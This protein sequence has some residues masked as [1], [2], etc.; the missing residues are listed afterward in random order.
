MFALLGALGLIVV[1]IGTLAAFGLPILGSL[2]L[3]V[4]GALG[5]EAGIARTLVQTTPLLFTSLGM[6]V[7]WRAGMG[8]HQVD[9]HKNRGP[10]SIEGRAHTLHSQS[11]ELGLIRPVDPAGHGRAH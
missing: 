5:S 1:L 4:H 9:M 7:A 2:Q 6:V 8:S 10:V 11:I 3:I